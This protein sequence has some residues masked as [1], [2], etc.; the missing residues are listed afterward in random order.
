MFTEDISRGT[1]Y[2]E[3]IFGIGIFVYYEVTKSKKDQ[4]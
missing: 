1:C 2:L 4:I 3:R